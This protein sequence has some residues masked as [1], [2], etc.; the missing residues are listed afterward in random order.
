[1]TFNGLSQKQKRKMHMDSLESLS[2]SLGLEK[3]LDLILMKIQEHVIA[4]HFSFYVYQPS[5][6]NYV[7]KAVRQVRS[8]ASIAPSYSGL[9]PYEKQPIS[10]PMTYPKEMLPSE[11]GQVK[12]GGGSF[13]FMPIEGGMGFIRMGPIKKL[14]NKNIKILN[15]YSSLLQ[16]PLKKLLDKIELVTELPTSQRKER[17]LSANNYALYYGYGQVKELSRFDL[18]IVEPKGYTNQEFQ[19]LKDSKKVVFTYL[20]LFEITPTDPIFQELTDDDFLSVDGQLLR[21]EAFGTY[22]VNLRSKK[23]MRHLLGSINHQLKDLSADGLFLDTIGDL[24][25]PV[26]PVAMK[27]IQLEATKN[28]LHVFKLLYPTHLLIQNNGLETVC[29]ETAPYIDGICWE[30]PPLTLPGSKEWADQIVQ[31]L[32][33]LKNEFQ[34][35]V[36]LLLEETVEKERESLT[37]TK[38]VADEN[39]FLLYNAPKDYLKLN[40]IDSL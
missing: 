27:K 13:L 1:M 9:L 26:I 30:N 3:T 34:L 23:W 36:F 12:E 24:E 4:P 14:Q 16:V 32:T 8:D 21:N 15:E 35:K 19:Q 7:L 10:S 33:F 38:T 6:G 31:R 18:M 37:S 40:S 39:G 25:N 29:L 28:F 11:I 20:S 5:R 2:H 17:M 22:L